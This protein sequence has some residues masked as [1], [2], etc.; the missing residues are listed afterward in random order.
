MR[1]YYS[2]PQVV[3]FACLNQP[4]GDCMNAQISMGM[5]QMNN[6][7]GDAVAN[8]LHLINVL[9]QSR[10]VENRQW[11]AQRLEQATLPT[12]RPY[13]EDALMTAVQM[14]RSPAVKI[15]AIRTLTSLKSTRPQVVALMSQACMHE[16]PR[17]REAA[18]EAIN[19]MMKQ[20]GI[21]QAGYSR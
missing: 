6:G 8:T 12:V 2:A 9:A 5:Y 3:P 19:T 11:A 15:A 1:A 16:D 10:E 4:F 18:G 7:Q 14:D 20:A 13:V 21:Q 17:I